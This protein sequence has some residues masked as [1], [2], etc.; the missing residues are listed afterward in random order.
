ML[1]VRRYVKW[2]AVKMR[3]G[4]VSIDQFVYY[5]KVRLGDATRLCHTLSGKV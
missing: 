4:H 3:F 2:S 5:V 1:P